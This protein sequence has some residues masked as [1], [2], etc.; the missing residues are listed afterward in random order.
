MYQGENFNNHEE[1]LETGD[2]RLGLVANCKKA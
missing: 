1:L 2:V